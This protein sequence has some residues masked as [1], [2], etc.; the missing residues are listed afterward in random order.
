MRNF[1]ARSYI[2]RRKNIISRES[3]PTREKKEMK[4]EAG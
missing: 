1:S 3:W 2:M 4:G